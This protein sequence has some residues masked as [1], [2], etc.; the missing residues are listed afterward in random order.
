MHI[1]FD[2]VVRNL[3]PVAYWLRFRLKI[4]SF[5]R[6]CDKRFPQTP[7]DLLRGAILK[8]LKLMPSKND[9]FIDRAQFRHLKV[10]K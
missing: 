5:A 7:P 6:L 4:Y 2:F 8:L 10:R 3:P 1:G 9:S